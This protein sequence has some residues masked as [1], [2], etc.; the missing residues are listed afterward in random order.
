MRLHAAMSTTS[1]MF[2]FVAGRKGIQIPEQS[3]V[4]L[5]NLYSDGTLLSVLDNS[6]EASI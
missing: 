2:S 6:S 5:A 1:F 4:L 3:A